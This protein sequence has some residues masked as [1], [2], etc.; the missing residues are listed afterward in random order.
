MN[1]ECEE[2]PSSS[3]SPLQELKD[4]VDNLFR[5]LPNASLGR[6][7]TSRLTKQVKPKLPEDDDIGTVHLNTV[8]AVK[9]SSFTR[10]GRKGDETE[11]IPGLLGTGNQTTNNTQQTQ[12]THNTHNNKQTNTNKRKQSDTDTIHNQQHTIEKR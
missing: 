9:D 2:E 3:A 6:F 7:P 11:A 10:V 8:D 12:T 5:S 1:S 4:I